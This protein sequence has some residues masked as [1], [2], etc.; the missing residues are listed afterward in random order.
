MPA[1]AHLSGECPAPVKKVRIKG[2]VLSWKAPANRGGA[3]D[4]VKY[5]VYKFDKEKDFDLDD[6]DRIVTITTDNSVQVPGSGVYV[7]TAR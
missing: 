4:A 7:V 2:D 6:T 1:Y 3:A 5:I